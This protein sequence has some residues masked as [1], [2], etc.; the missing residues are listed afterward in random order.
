MDRGHSGCRERAASALAVARRGAGEGIEIAQIGRLAPALAYH[1]VAPFVS[2]QPEDVAVRQSVRFLEPVVRVF[3][4]Q[5]ES[6]KI[7]VELVGGMLFHRAVDD[8]EMQ[9]AGARG[10]HS[11]EGIEAEGHRFIK[12]VQ[13][14]V[15]WSPRGGD[16]GNVESFYSSGRTPVI[17]WHF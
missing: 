16:T 14:T 15:P 13:A 8:A 12:S 5:I 2:D 1:P 4:S 11:G 3:K 9:V 6:P 10:G 7:T 17:V